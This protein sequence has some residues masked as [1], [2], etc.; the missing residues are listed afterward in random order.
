M[1]D[2]AHVRRRQSKP[3]RLGR[4]AM[5]SEL[6]TGPRRRTV[7]QSPRAPPH[8]T[9][10]PTAR[11]G[12]V[13]VGRCARSRQR[14]RLLRPGRS[15]SWR[16]TGRRPAL[17]PSRSGSRARQRWSFGFRR[18]APDHATC[19]GGPRGVG[20]ERL[21]NVQPPLRELERDD[22]SEPL[23]EG[24]DRPEVVSER[25]D[26]AVEPA[27]VV[28]VSLAGKHDRRGILHRQVIHARDRPCLRVDAQHGVVVRLDDVQ[29]VPVREQ[30]VGHA[31]GLA[32]SVGPARGL[33]LDGVRAE[34]RAYV[35]H[36]LPRAVGV[37]LR[38]PGWVIGK[39]LGAAAGLEGDVHRP[40]EPREVRWAE[41]V[42]GVVNDARQA[43]RDRL[44]RPVGQDARYPAGEARLVRP[45]LREHV[46]DEVA[47]R[48][49][50]GGRRAAYSGLRDV[51]VPVRAEANVP[52]VRQTGCERRHVVGCV[53][54]VG[55]DGPPPE[56]A[57]AV[58]RSAVAARASA[59][60]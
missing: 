21:E 29:V 19:P 51:E 28:R 44:P 27:E 3:A 38:D 47:A 33:V 32:V 24:L 11:S 15:S 16:R 48:S 6:I 1:R 52:R 60:R 8:R 12:S 46:V 4:R 17:S 40:A 58:A 31:V 42:P 13:S 14:P 53:T 43:G 9:A 25:L 57:A 56:A 59:Q 7:P 55:C 10:G 34:E 50:H 18:F 37:D 49:R 39:P 41:G 36:D 2:V 5:R 54:F 20:A 22:R 30:R 45:V 26:E 35:G 23:V